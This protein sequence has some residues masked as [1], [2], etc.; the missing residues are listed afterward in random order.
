M[1]TTTRTT[2]F[3]SSHWWSLLLFQ[4]VLVLV[5]NQ[6]SSVSAQ[7]TDTDA[8]VV[9][10]VTFTYTFTMFYAPDVGQQYAY[11][12]VVGAAGACLAAELNEYNVDVNIVNLTAEAVGDCSTTVINA[13]ENIGLCIESVGSVVVEVDE[14]ID[15]NLIEKLSAGRVQACIVTFN[16]DNPNEIHLGYTSPIPLA[17]PI[18]VEMEGV[19]TELVPSMAEFL[20]QELLATLTPQLANQ[21][22]PF[23]LVDVKI[24]AQE[25]QVEGEEGRRRR[26]VIGDQNQNINNNHRQL[27]GDITGNSVEVILVGNCANVD[28]ANNCDRDS[29]QSVAKKVTEE[30]SETILEILQAVGQ[31]RTYFDRVESLEVK[32]GE[33]LVTINVTAILDKTSD[34]PTLEEFSQDD[35]PEEEAPFWIWILVGGSAGVLLVGSIWA[36][37]AYK[38]RNKEALLRQAFEENHR[39]SAMGILSKE[40]ASEGYQDHPHDHEPRGM[41][42]SPTEEDMPMDESHGDLGAVPDT[43]D[44]PIAAA[45][46]ETTV[47]KSMDEDS[48]PMDEQQ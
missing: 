44:S 32:Q 36:T 33:S 31:G 27:Q 21:N 3:N 14:V 39:Q 38:E 6:L 16:E 30:N 40:P 43:D 22:P 19:R 34:I 29:V 7:T 12:R 20:R 13:P 46:G 1:T 2:H 4:L 42:A 15:F 25:L 26:L 17:V 47:D 45:A 48:V 24:V 23:E 18:I 8:V 10:N 11:D 37:Q 41:M 35:T 9:T 28:G 5:S